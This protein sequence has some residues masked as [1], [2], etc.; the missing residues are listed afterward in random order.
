MLILQTTYFIY[1]TWKRKQ[2]TEQQPPGSYERTTSKQKQNQARHIQINHEFYCSI[3][4]TNNAMAS[5]KDDFFVWHPVN[6]KNTD[7]TLTTILWLHCLTSESNGRFLVNNILIFG[8]LW[9]LVMAQ[10]QF[11]LTNKS[12]DW[13]SRT[14]TNSLPTEVR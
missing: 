6:N 11:S 3:W 12:K 7:Q 1:T 14:L 9:C 10:N 2:T 13:T 8:S 4:P 5:L